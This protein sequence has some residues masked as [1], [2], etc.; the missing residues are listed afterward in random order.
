MA[1]SATLLP[2]KLLLQPSNAPMKGIMLTMVK[3]LKLV[4]KQPGVM[5]PTMPSD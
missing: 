5:T 3:I 1:G 4:N 2:K